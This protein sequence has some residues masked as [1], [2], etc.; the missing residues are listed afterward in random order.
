MRGKYSPINYAQKY[1]LEI[2]RTPEQ[3]WEIA[4]AED[5]SYTRILYYRELVNRYPEHKYAPQALFMIGFVYAEELQDL[6][7]ARRT[8]DELLKDYPDSE[9]V[10]SSKWMIENLY[11][12]H[13]RFESLEGVQEHL[14][15]DKE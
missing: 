10:E 13:P 14:E 3:L 7:Q 12:D 2:T 6:V 11:E 5:A 15:K 4:Q 1:V 8:F 9:V